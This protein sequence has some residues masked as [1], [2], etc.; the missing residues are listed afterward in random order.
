MFW[1]LQLELEAGALDGRKAYFGLCV[2]CTL[3]C[4]CITFSKQKTKT[5]EFPVVQGVKDLMLSLLRPWLLLWLRFDP[6]PRNF[7]M[8]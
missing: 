6:W 4:I 3:E 1:Y 7:H 8:P 2:S 5:W